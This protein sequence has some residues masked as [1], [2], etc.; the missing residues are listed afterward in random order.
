M[1]KKNKKEQRETEKERERVEGEKRSRR[2]GKH[3]AL[4]INLLDFNSSV[5]EGYGFHAI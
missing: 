4:R 5:E 3:Q 1:N 2:R